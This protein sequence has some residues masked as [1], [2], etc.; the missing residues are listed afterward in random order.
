[1]KNLFQK[2]WE[3]AKKFLIGILFGLAFA[4]ILWGAASIFHD[5]YQDETVAWVIAFGFGIIF[6]IWKP[7]ENIFKK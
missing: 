7:V 3:G 4:I 6:L 2:I 1:M 5:N